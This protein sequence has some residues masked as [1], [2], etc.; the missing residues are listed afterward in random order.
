MDE[1]IVSS[2]ADADKVI[3]GIGEDWNGQGE[4]AKAGYE[5]LSKLIEGK[6]YYV[7]SLC[8]DGV[9]DGCGFDES[10]LVTPNDENDD[11]WEAY[12]AW[13]ARTLNHKLCLLELG[14]GL[15]YPG[16]IRWPF[17]K[18]VYV[19]QKSIMYRVHKSLYQGTAETGERCVGIKADAL[20]YVL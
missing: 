20:E 7:V 6:D 5:A 16:V 4:R 10:R 15:K 3:I 13:L 11:K 9:I 12:N 19:N 8:D 18:V 1:R 17:E 14:V 2:V